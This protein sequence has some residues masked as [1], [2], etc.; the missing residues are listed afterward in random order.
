MELRAQLHIHTTASK[1]ARVYVESLIPPRELPRLLA[2]HGINVAAITDHE[3]TA[4]YKLVREAAKPLGILVIRGVELETEGGHLIGIGIGE[5]IERKIRGRQLSVEEAAEA[6][7]ELG[8]EVYAPHPFDML[9]RGV[10]DAIAR[11]DCIV[12]VFNP[13][14]MLPLFDSLALKAARKLR[15]PTAVG[16]DAHF[17]DM[18]PLAITVVEAGQTEDEVLN[19]IRR[20]RVRF[21]NCRYVRLS[22]LKDWML[23]RAALSYPVLRERI[24]RGVGLSRRLSAIENPLF[25]AIE[26]LALEA[27]VRN[28]GSWAWD[29]L[30]KISF[31]VAETI[32]GF[33]SLKDFAKLSKCAISN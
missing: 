25:K 12:E 8:G 11:M 22:Q 28:A 20:G 24:K 26:L 19:A 5:G 16:A 21:E 29:L 9:G 30:A 6:I 33:K 31:C 13:L 27:A 2:L 17:P 1:G 4:A 3:T 32:G 15:R 18:L 10:G 23:R 14:S 7:R